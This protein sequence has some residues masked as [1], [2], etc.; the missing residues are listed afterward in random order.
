VGG[1]V[2]FAVGM[3]AVRLVGPG[4]LKW[5]AGE[6]VRFEWTLLCLGGQFLVLAWCSR[7]TRRQHVPR[8]MSDA[9]WFVPVYVWGIECLVDAA[10]YGAGHFGWPERAVGD[11][12]MLIVALALSLSAE[13]WARRLGCAARRSQGSVP[14]PVVA[15]VLS[16]LLTWIAILVVSMIRVPI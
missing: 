16:V 3:A 2:L 15:A 8:P 4:V 5:V 11:V 14:L 6:L 7:R 9:T 12:I 10:N 1:G 13:M